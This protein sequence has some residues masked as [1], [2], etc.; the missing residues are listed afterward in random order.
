MHDQMP[1]PVITTLFSIFSIYF[2]F[3]FNDFTNILS[4]T[5]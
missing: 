3:I 2:L 4:A 1:I 5:R